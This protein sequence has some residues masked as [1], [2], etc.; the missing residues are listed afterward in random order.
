MSISG[1]GGKHYP[2][3]LA[4]SL[5]SG[6]NWDTHHISEMNCIVVGTF[7]YG[8][9]SIIVSYT[10][11]PT[12][13]MYCS[14]QSA[15]GAGVIWSMRREKIRNYN[16]TMYVVFSSIEYDSSSTRLWPVGYVH[17]LRDNRTHGRRVGERVK[18]SNVLF[19]VGSNDVVKSNSR[20]V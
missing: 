16:K 2:V 9:S 3:I 14:N 5:N 7:Y 17:C 20:L 4:L 19:E 15:N 11:W 6:I 12:T 10:T 8:N 1:N 18:S 13:Y